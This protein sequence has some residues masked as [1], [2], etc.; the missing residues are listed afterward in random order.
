VGSDTATYGLSSVEPNSM[1]S[2]RLI[3]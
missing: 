3:V 1:V 2:P